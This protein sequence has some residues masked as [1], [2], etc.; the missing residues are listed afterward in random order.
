MCGVGG[1]LFAMVWVD[2]E[3]AGLN[4]SGALPAAATLEG[5]V[6]QRGIGSATVPGAPAGWAALAQRFGTRSVD[7]LAH[8]AIPP[9][10]D[11]VERSPGL[12]PVTAR[13]RAP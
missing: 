1:D 11:G 9:A 5:S 8:P 6:P 13:A 7:D 4:S 2:G 3:I 10:R 12:T